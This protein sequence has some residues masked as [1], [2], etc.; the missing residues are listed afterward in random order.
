METAAWKLYPNL[1]LLVQH[2]IGQGYYCEFRTRMPS[3]SGSEDACAL[4]REDAGFV[5]ADL[6]IVKYN[7]STQDASARFRRDGTNG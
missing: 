3:V 2:S 1:E 6:P 4:E 7:M 5:E